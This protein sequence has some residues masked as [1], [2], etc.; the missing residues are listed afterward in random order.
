MRLSLFICIA[1]LLG[2]AHQNHVPTHTASS[3]PDDT[4]L[5]VVND[6]RPERLRTNS[7]GTKYSAPIAYAH[8]PQLKRLSQ[9]IAQDYDQE[10]LLEWPLESL[11]VHCFVIK[12]PDAITLAKLN[13]D[14]RVAWV[15]PFNTHT[16]KTS[17]ASK[18][19]SRATAPPNPLPIAGDAAGVRL[20]VIDTGADLQHQ[21]LSNKSIFYRDLV[22]RPTDVNHGHNESHGTSILGLLAAQPKADA[23]IEGIASGATFQHL[24]GCW[25]EEGI[26]RCNT[27]TLALAL[28]A[29]IDWQPAIINLSLSGPS[30][31]V[32]DALIAR[33]TD[34]GTL[35]V[36]AFDDERELDSRFP[37]PSD[38]VIYAMA[39]QT[40]KPHPDYA[41][42]FVAPGH[43]F[44]LSP[45]NEYRLVSG[46]SVA[47]PYLT[48]ALARLVANGTNLSGPDLVQRLNHALI[49]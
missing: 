36:S 11:S 6:P 19:I 25:E 42:C 40:M 17:V 46:H 24:R 1:T 31:R 23:I 32:L 3:I 34:S 21:D 27:F 22:A 9:S 37:S 41:H 49:Q 10:V 43:A 45:M 4:V 35:V 16:L 13:N 38:H 8:D 26:G 12:R 29:A 39:G 18:A 28:E 20:T 15:Q 48:A 33:L 2:C 47:T 7:Y 5:I 30:D 14:P 44:S